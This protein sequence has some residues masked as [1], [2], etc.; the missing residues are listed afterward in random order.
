MKPKVNINRKKVSTEEI[1]ANKDFNSVFNQYQATA[2][3]QK[4]F[5]QKP[6]VITAGITAITGAIL[7][8]VYGNLFNKNVENN[9]DLNLTDS[10][11]LIVDSV[12]SPFVNPPVSAAEISFTTYKVESNKAYTLD[13]YTGSKLNVPANAFLDVNGSPITGEILLK[14]REFKKSD[15]FF[16][17]GIPMTY[18]SAGLSYT[19]ESAGMMEITAEQNGLPVFANPEHPIEVEMISEQT[20]DIY[21]EYYLDTLAREWQYLGHSDFK[22]YEQPESNNGASLIAMEEEE[23][24]NQDVQKIDQIKSELQVIAKDIKDIKTKIPERPKKVNE[25]KPTFRIDVDPKEFP[26][27]MAFND[28]YWEVG[29]ENKGFTDEY[30]NVTWDDVK[31]S[32]NN[33]GQSYT[34]TLTKDKRVEHL[35]V[36]PR[37]GDSS[38]GK[39]CDNFDK[40]YETYLARLDSR[41]KDEAKKQQEYDTK[42]A[43][44]EEKRK[45]WEA[46]MAEKR[47]KWEEAQ[48]NA[49]RIA[50][51]TNRVVRNFTANRFGI[52]NC[53]NPQKLP[54]GESVIANF[55]DKSGKTIM[56]TKI[57]LASIDRNAMYTYNIN[58]PVRWNPKHENVLWG[59]T[60]E[61]ELAVF[62]PKDFNKVPE[63]ISK[64]TFEMDTDG[65]ALV[66][67]N[68]IKEFLGIEK[69]KR[70][71]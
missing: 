32:E 29:A 16:I 45:A 23:F 70:N 47:R 24:V 53:D 55:K 14:Y 1:R 56:L 44:L 63:N 22:P 54:K 2:A 36:K 42:L 19:F 64:Y 46:Q 10:N 58:K 57:Y 31:I 5:Y 26:E 37:Y 18:D 50:A 51:S 52:F 34:L 33:K 65:D 4:P 49:Q 11:N 27:I 20:E 7:L 39:A 60:S 38:Y 17:S 8:G 59:I 21:N 12:L 25:K 40:K 43:D 61:N 62:R 3:I 6:W 9:S 68:T 41:L 13:Y 15:D 69:V 28:L 66:S 48:I 71:S 30:Y 35:F 67:T